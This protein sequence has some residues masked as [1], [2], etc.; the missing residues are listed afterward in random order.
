MSQN[1]NFVEMEKQTVE[2]YN[3]YYSLVMGFQNKYLYLRITILTN[4]TV[5]LFSEFCALL[6]SR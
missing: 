4:I 5:H 1:E 2:K 6:T 3:I